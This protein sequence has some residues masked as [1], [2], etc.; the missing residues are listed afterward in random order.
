MWGFAIQKNL[1]ICYSS[2]N[3]VIRRKAMKVPYLLGSLSSFPWCKLLWPNI[4]P[5]FLSVVD[6]P[7]VYIHIYT[8][9][10]MHAHTCIYYDTRILWYMHIYTHT[11]ICA[12]I[13]TIHNIINIVDIWNHLLTYIYIYIYMS[14]IHTQYTHVEQQPESNVR[15]ST[16]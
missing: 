5:A 8:S 16:F 1:Q 2:M 11:Y 3:L 9:T 6:G 10:Y 7:T 15:S 4:S 14:Y 13:H 12:H